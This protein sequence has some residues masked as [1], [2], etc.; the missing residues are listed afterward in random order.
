MFQP[1]CIVRFNMC[2]FA[3]S[4]RQKTFVINHGILLRQ[5]CCQNVICINYFLN[6]FAKDVYACFRAFIT[7]YVSNYLHEYHFLFH[8]QIGTRRQIS[9][10][11]SFNY[12]ELYVFLNI[13]VYEPRL[14]G[15]YYKHRTKSAWVLQLISV[16][17]Y[18]MFLL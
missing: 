18:Y 3:I 5:R 12:N 7:A 1:H 13:S 16:Y 4:W 8:I 2:S 6:R 14:Y 9:L 17:S 15:R 10:N 11:Y